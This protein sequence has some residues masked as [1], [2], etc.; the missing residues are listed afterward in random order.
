[1]NTPRIRT[2]LQAMPA[3]EGGIKYFDV[4]DPRSGSR[5]RMYD[6]EWLIAERMDGRRPFDEVASWARERLGI[7]PSAADLEDYAR[8]LRELGFF[9]VEA[10][11]A[12]VRAAPTAPTLMAEAPVLP[13]TNGAG[14]PADLDSDKTAVPPLVAEGPLMGGSA[15]A[16]E[17][18]APPRPE[19]RPEARSDE[20][21]RNTGPVATAPTTAMPVVAP[22]PMRPDVP[23][24]PAAR[25]AAEPPRPTAA[26]AAE[27]PRS[28]AASIVGIIVVLLLVGGLVAYVKLMGGAPAKVTTVIATPREVVRLYDGAATIKK[29]DVQT[30]SFGE[31]GTVSDVVAP[32]TEAKA[33]MPL[34]TLDTYA[35][36]EKELADVKDRESYY[37]KQL[38]AA[39]A[40]NEPAA[41]KAA[42][43]KVA[44]KKKLVAEYEARAA[45][46]RLV[47]PGPGTVSAVLVQAGAQA[48]AG[49]PVVRLTDARKLATFTLPPTDA[50]Q[51]KPGQPVSLQEAS[52]GAPMSGRVVKV[53]GDGVTVEVAE[54]APAKP[55]DQVRLVKARVPNVIPVPA[56]AVVH[57]ANGDVVYVLA[58]GVVHE[59]KVSVV[60]RSG[61][62]ALVGNG[63]QSGDQVVAAGADGLHDGQKAAAQ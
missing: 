40:K 1:M 57:R 31:A 49:D 33:G 26:A 27:P 4:S 18:V 60:D 58:D 2:D 47:A 37:T 9:E 10:E 56:T 20:R 30:L 46:V 53:E 55:G 19:P 23:R 6:F 15:P 42:E 21:P 34:A 29:A 36:V 52:G 62:E 3:E 5:M 39:Q 41:I 61:T 14:K 63:L 25:P 59:H 43:A 45:K 54:D 48:K 11:E 35:K 16:M 22:P 12:P 44:E 28:N 24:T 7:Q 32:G 8:R 51:M 38:Q 17:A 50:G 13:A